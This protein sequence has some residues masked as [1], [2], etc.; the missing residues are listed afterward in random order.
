LR[1]EIAGNDYVVEITGK[2][3]SGKDFPDSAH[4]VLAAMKDPKRPMTGCS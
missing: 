3:I 4:T 1:G 2:K